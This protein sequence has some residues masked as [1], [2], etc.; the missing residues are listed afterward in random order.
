[1]KTTG[2]KAFLAHFNIM[3]AASVCLEEIKKVMISLSK[4]RW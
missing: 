1:M 2:Q 4:V 3:Q